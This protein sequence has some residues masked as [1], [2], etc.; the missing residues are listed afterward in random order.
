MQDLANFSDWKNMSLKF[1]M[2]IDKDNAW[3]AAPMQIYF[4]SSSL[5]SNGAA[6]V[7]DIYGNTLAG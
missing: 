7:K 1:E 3:S 6:G 2:Y 4:G 5:V